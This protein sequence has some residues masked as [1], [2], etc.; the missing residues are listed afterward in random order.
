M[1]DGP[2]QAQLKAELHYEPK[3]GVF[4][5]VKP[6]YHTRN[7]KPAGSLDTHGHRQIRV[8]KKLQL[9]HRLAW[10][11]M[12]GEW[13]EVTIDHEDRQRDNNRWKNLRKATQAQNC[14]NQGLRKNNKSGYQGVHWC[15]KRKK[16]IASI[17][18]SM[19]KVRLGAFDDPKAASAC[20]QQGKSAL[21]FQPS[22]GAA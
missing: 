5:R 2:T 22:T 20:Y 13:P 1:K 4:T 14:Q 16:W 3:T 17:S 10:L 15:S 11:Y 9:A 6:T 7:G 19:R 8:C 21:H 18:V 12:T